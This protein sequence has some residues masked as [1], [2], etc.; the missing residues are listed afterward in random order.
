MAA[1]LPPRRPRDG[2]GGAARRWQPAAGAARVVRVC[3]GAARRVCHS[4]RPWC[5]RGSVKATFLGVGGV[6]EVGDGAVGT[7]CARLSGRRER[8]QLD[9]GGG[10]WGGRRG[11]G[12]CC[13]GDGTAVESAAP[14]A[15]TFGDTQHRQIQGHKQ[16]SAAQRASVLPPPRPIVNLSSGCAL[17]ERCGQP[18]AHRQPLWIPP[19]RDGPLCR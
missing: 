8:R 18:A 3:R 15:A 14:L 4:C 9:D 5:V 17:M 16:Q 11:G 19:A 7:G 12:G 13:G 10:V 1:G 6:W 2:L